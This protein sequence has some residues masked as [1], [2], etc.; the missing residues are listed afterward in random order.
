MQ[1]GDRSQAVA[2]LLSTFLGF[3]GVD[4]FYMGSIWLGVAKLLTLG[5]FTLW[6]AVDVLLIGMGVARDGEGKRLARP[7]STEGP[8]QAVTYLL[9][10]FLGVFGV[11]RFYLGSILLGVLKLVTLGGLGLWALIDVFLVGMGLMRDGKGRALA[12]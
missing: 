5:G 3:L 7:A 1:Q 8:S 10:V 6:W 4:R 2:F 9:S 12:S 11:D